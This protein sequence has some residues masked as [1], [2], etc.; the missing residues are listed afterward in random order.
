[1][2]RDRAGVQL[3]DRRA[4]RRLWASSSVSFLRPALSTTTLGPRI[5]RSRLRTRARS[6][7]GSMSMSSLTS[8]IVP[9]LTWLQP[10]NAGT[11][12]EPVT[13]AAVEESAAALRKHLPPTPLQHSPAFSNKAACHVYL[14]IE[15]SQPIRAFKVR[16][17][18]NK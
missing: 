14:K 16:G 11:R 8:S 5:L 7:G 2:T 15:S 12:I 17:A 13:Q 3:A 6:R 1:Q 9:G 4:A 18:L 10:M